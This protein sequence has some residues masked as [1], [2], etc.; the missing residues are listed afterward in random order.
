M[1]RILCA[2]LVCVFAGTADLCSGSENDDLVRLVVPV[3]WQRFADPPP[4]DDDYRLSVEILLN[5]ARYNVQWAVGAA[6]RIE[7]DWREL[8]GREPHDVIRPAC[9]AAC[10]LA[11]VLKTG[12]FDERIVGVSQAET[13]TRTVRLIHAAA[14]AHDGNRSF[15]PTT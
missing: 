2:F 13:L 8:S 7:A 5:T 11:V 4:V 6:N 14:V 3:D 1:S 10:A 12:I 15:I 9:E